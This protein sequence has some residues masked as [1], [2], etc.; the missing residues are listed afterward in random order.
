MVGGVLE[1]SSLIVGYR[2]LLLLVGLL[3]AV[4]FFFGRQRH[5]AQATA[6]MPIPIAMIG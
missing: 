3:Y 2:S 6:Q 5:S 1:Y 4:A